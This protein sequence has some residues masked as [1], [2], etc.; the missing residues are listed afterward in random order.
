MKAKYEV[1]G[2]VWNGMNNS[3]YE[4]KLW[5]DWSQHP[6]EQHE[7]DIMHHYMYIV[8]YHVERIASYI[9]PSFDRADLKSL[10]LIG[11]YDAL[12]KFEP[13]RNLKFATYA[14]IRVHGSIMDGL[15]KED[16]LPRALR[17]KA[18]QIEKTSDMLHQQLDRIPTSL[19]IAEA[20]QIQPE[21]VETTIANTMFANVQSLDAHYEASESDNNVSVG[22]YVH[23][24]SIPTPID[25]LMTSELKEELMKSIKELNENEQLV[26]NLFYIEE[27]T[28]TE[29]GKVLELTTSR[30]SQIHKRAIF[31]LRVILSKIQKM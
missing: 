21:E 8:D 18:K 30:I 5:A 16:W 27:L 3:Q 25:H 14:T 19:D 22:S 20:L 7:N 24:H 13:K 15:R 1:E 31:K 23:D 2:G 10:G 29:I 12:Q 28:L 9:P 26:I 11:L 4:E 6:N 17:D